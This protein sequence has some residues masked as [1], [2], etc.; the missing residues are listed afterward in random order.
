MKK[1]IDRI[2][3]EETYTHLKTFENV[4]Q[5]NVTVRQYKDTIADMGL[6]KDL[7]RNLLTILEYLKRH[8]CRYFGVSFK[9]KRKIAADLEMSDKTI[10]RLC[11]HLETLGVIKQYAM[12]RPTDMLQ[13]AD[14][15]VIQ[16]VECRLGKKNNRQDDDK[17]SDQKNKTSLKQNNLLHNTYQPAAPVTF[18]G[19]FKDFIER[20]IGKDQHLTSRLFGVYKAHTNVLLK[21]GAFSRQDVEEAGLQSLKSA[22]M[23]TKTK[24]IRNLPGYFN[25]ALDQMLDKLY[26]DAIQLEW[27]ECTGHP[28]N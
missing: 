28:K 16:P 1:R 8:S 21:H 6:R 12:K 2:A 14:A 3:G 5:M 11:K 10:T 4:E 15:I 20:T 22:V 23:A 26:F 24:K 18:Y 9:G 27:T 7:K 25:G 19:C 13:T 17:M